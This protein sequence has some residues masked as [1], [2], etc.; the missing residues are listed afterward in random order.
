MI[1]Y[2]F[3]REANKLL[4]KYA[5]P[6]AELE[7]IIDNNRNGSWLSDV[8]TWDEFKERKSQFASKE[9][10][11]GVVDKYSEIYSQVKESRIFE[12]KNIYR[13]ADW[14]K[15]YPIHEQ[16]LSEKCK[17]HKYNEMK[18][19]AFEVGD[20]KPELTINSKVLPSRYQVFEYLPKNCI[21]AEVGVAFGGFS[22]YILEEMKPTSFYAIDMYDEQLEGFWNKNI[23]KEQKITHYD[24][25]EKEF[26]DYIDA[27]VLKMHKSISWDAMKAYP[28]NYFDY[29]YLDA[30]HDYE[31]VKKDIE[32]IYPKMKKGS[33][34][35]FNDY[36][37]GTSNVYYGVIPL[38]NKFINE[39]DSEVLYFCF[40]K[41]GYH[42]L[43]VRVN[44]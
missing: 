16:L 1:L 44:K 4:R 30:A 23:F 10:C 21:A 42:D 11:I 40:E 15:K 12:E 19:K 5:V 37:Y 38:V 14:I 29:L 27:G 20:I 3:G 36:T 22:K 18:E 39:T 35:Q 9:I 31:S 8:V 6:E 24:W 13:L 32:A 43:V 2:G 34:I 25:Y 28:D 33:I 41:G 7:V 26:K 17:Q